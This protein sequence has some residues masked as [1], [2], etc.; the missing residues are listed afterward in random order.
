MDPLRILFVEDLA[1]DA[2][3][4]RREISKEKITFT[5]RVVDTEKEFRKALAEFR[6]DLIVSDY[7]MPQ[8]DGMSALR[9]TRS[10]PD[11]I[12]FIM[13]TGSMNEETAVAC[14]KE[15]ADDYV[16][17]E[18]IRRLPFAVRETLEMNHV[19]RERKR[20]LSAL[21]RSEEKY[22]LLI[23]NLNEGLMQVDHN[24]RILYVNEA[25]CRMFGYSEEELTGK[26]GYKIL[27]FKEDQEIIKE[28][29]R[30]R[31]ETPHERYE[32][33]GRKKTGEII[34]LSISG[35]AVTDEKGKVTGS[36]GLLTD[37]T[38][39]KRAEE[40]LRESELRFKTLF[41]ESPVSIIIHDKETGEIIDA[42]ES[43]YTAY[44]LNS[45]DDLKKNAFWTEPPYSADDAL[46]WI[47]KAAASGI[48]TFEWK[49]RR[50][51]GRFFWEFVTLRR[52]VV[53][54]VERILATSVDITE[55]KKAEETMYEQQALLT[56]IYRNALL[57]LMVVDTDRRIQ[58]VNGFA[59]QFAGRDVKEMVGLRGGE[60]LRCLHALDDPKGCG[61]GEFCQQCIIRNTV[62]DTLETAKTHLQVE[63]PYHFLKDEKDVQE[64][65]FLTSTT[66]IMVKNERM[67]L[68]TLQDITDRKR[69][70]DKLLESENRMR[71]IIE[72]TP[73][74]FFYTQD[75]DAKITYISPSVEVITGYSV[76]DWL[77]SVDWFITDNK[78]NDYA[79]S[80]TRAHL[81]GEY[82]KGPI[83]LEIWHADKHSIW[84]EIY[85]TPVFCDEKVVGIQGVAHDITERKK[86]EEALQISLQEKTRLIGELYHRTKNNMQVIMSMLSIQAGRMKNERLRAVV[87][88]SVNRI[89]TMALVHEKLYQSRSLSRI[90]LDD[91]IRELAQL[92]VRTYNV[93]PGK[94]K[95]SFEL[96][97]IPALIDYAV[98]CGLILN[99]LISNAFKYA[100]P[101]GQSGSVRVGLRRI[102][103]KKTIELTV[104][105]NGIGLP[106]NYD[107]RSSS[108]FGLPIIVA[109]A[110]HQLQGK[111]EFQG[112]KGL[113]C[114]VVFRDDQYEERV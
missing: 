83:P 34:W 15:G 7:A 113:T 5:F 29:N 2:E 89:Q 13:L 30:S 21:R 25:L 8:F 67:A 33:R 107:Y 35:S 11:Y 98:P 70:Q 101:K 111:I 52:V 20:A 1:A 40:R 18:K 4:A 73:H 93:S 109:I 90:N 41:N 17:K 114:R 28:K 45:L 26:I 92:L 24:D 77:A 62:L 102:R 38:E 37:I 27:I 85:E 87:Q 71:A 84:L 99:E 43:A 96:D 22:H 47:R 81:R 9:I 74:L 78:L 79:R 59:A 10:Q 50:A 91:Y 54:G 97:P 44:G 49:N 106:H 19:R 6:P 95:L 39:G 72:G 31:T 76:S 53:N 56:A 61:F 104:S 75:T 94:I 65:T 86:A 12:P 57:V 46:K 112:E 64:M 3:M 14:M 108:T 16:L 69:A 63:A 58:Q 103:E 42:N 100:F 82:T 23:R 32:I 110:E 88:E 68:V 48:Q 51:D 55:R 66:P 105:D 60:A 80:R 36:V